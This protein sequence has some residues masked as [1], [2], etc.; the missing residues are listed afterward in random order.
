MPTLPCTQ[1]DVPPAPEW[2]R[3]SAAPTVSW[4]LAPLVRSRGY[5][6]TTLAEATGLSS[7][8][9]A[10]AIWHGV[11]GE[12]ERLV[13]AAELSVDVLTLDQLAE[14]TQALATEEEGWD[15]SAGLSTAAEEERSMLSEEKAATLL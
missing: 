6:V 9:V 13:L 10:K 5:T 11:L 14:E 3:E 15:T 2:C 12:R 1:L 8:V 4:G 7:S